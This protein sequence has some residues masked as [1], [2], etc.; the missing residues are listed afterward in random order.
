MPAPRAVAAVLGL[1]ALFP[2]SFVSV[3]AESSPE[4]QQ[5][6][7]Q[8]TE[9]RQSYEARLQAL[10][11]RIAELQAS[12]PVAAATSPAPAPATPAQPSAAPAT[13]MGGGQSSASAFN[14]AISLILA[15]TYANLSRN[16]AGYKL[17]GFMP[18]GGE[19]G[20]GERSFRLGESELAINASIDPLFSGRFIAALGADNSVEVEE[21]WFEHQ[22]IFNGATLRGGRFLSSIGYLNNHHAHTWDFVDAPLVYQAFFGGPIKTDGLQLRWLA[23]TDRYL[24]FGAEVGSGTSFPGNDTGRNGV[25]STAL[26]AHVGD[27]LGDSASWRAGAS[28]LHHRA[29]DRAYD[30]INAAGTAVTNSFTGTN[31]TWVL[32]GIFKWAPGGNAVRQNLTIQG[33]YFR[34]TESGSLSYDTLAQAGGP[35][36]GDYRAAPSGWYLQTVYQFMPKWR[37]GARYD[38]LDSGTPRLGMLGTN[39]VTAGDFPILQNARPSR[40]T[41]M[42]DYSPSEFSR[43]RLQFAADRS[44][45][46]ATD[47]QLFLQYIMSL[48]A[49]GA[50]AF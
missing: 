15:G 1:A 37:V 29:L 19:V 41:L 2:I 34:R 3:A 9:L 30:D 4:L 24:E 33:E 23:P 16:P 36:S 42:F 6:K 10:E 47:R 7:D 8:I 31:R 48:G 39:G 21:A 27:D 25:G 14:P 11:K 38:R 12:P 20:P 49:H 40:S 43:L 46:A 26:F 13:A 5:L 22:G 32:D 35:T 18:S 45:P 50:H 28:W 44:N 17:Q